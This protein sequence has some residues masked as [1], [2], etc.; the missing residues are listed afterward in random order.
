MFDCKLPRSVDG[1][2]WNKWM[3]AGSPHKSVLSTQFWQMLRNNIICKI[4]LNTYSHTYLQHVLESALQGVNSAEWSNEETTTDVILCD[5]Q[6]WRCIAV[7]RVSFRSSPLR[8]I[9]LA[10]NE[11]STGRHKVLRCVLRTAHYGGFHSLENERLFFNIF[12]S[13]LCSS[14][15][16]MTLLTWRRWQHKIRKEDG[17]PGGA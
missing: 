4:H 3:V 13:F 2:V 17:V 14:E 9:Y 10:A 15:R 8:Q 5:R 6:L 12:L 1:T 16:R 7:P 11:G